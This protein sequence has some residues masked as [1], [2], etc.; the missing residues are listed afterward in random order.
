MCR[1]AASVTAN[2][3]LSAAMSVLRDVASDRPVKIAAAIAAPIATTAAPALTTETTSARVHPFW[4]IWTALQVAVPYRS[5]GRQFVRPAFH[6]GGR[7]VRSM[8]A[9]ASR[10]RSASSDTPFRISP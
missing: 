10:V 2:H 4:P 5:S 3:G 9:A 8:N 7:S 1:W 6:F